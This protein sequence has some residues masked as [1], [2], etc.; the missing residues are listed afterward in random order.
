[1]SDAVR[2]DAERYSAWFAWTRSALGRT[3]DATHAAA[4]AAYD[5]EAAG[6]SQEDARAAAQGAGSEPA[7][8]DA[9]TMAIAEWAAWAGGTLGTAPS[10]SLIAARYAVARVA[11]THDLDG[12]MHEVSDVLAARHPSPSS[13]VTRNRRLWIIGGIAA[14]VLVL[15]GATAG[16]VGYAIEAS[17]VPSAKPGQPGP[18]GLSVNVDLASG[19]AAVDAWGL[20]PDTPTFLFVGDETVRI[21][22]TNGKGG[23]ETTIP[24]PPGTSR[25]AVC[26][27]SFGESCPASTVV[28]R[29]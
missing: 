9:E 11:E 12:V 16:L 21:L 29:P 4:L 7:G 23:F 14:T 19:D 25:V 18:A 5:A 27:D 10:A 1:M 6:G 15:G 28:T 17:A 8:L 20:P 3:V 24:V 22:Q 26:L 13:S 2:V